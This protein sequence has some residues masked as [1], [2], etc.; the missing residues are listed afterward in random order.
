MSR[1]DFCIM[2]N[3][4]ASSSA[5]DSEVVSVTSLSIGPLI[6]L[7][8]SKPA[9]AAAAVSLGDGN[10]EELSSCNKDSVVVIEGVGFSVVIVIAF[11]AFAIG[12]MLMSSLWFIYVKT[13]K[14]CC[15]HHSIIN[16]L[17][18]EWLHANLSLK[19]LIFVCYC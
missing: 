13:S 11:A 2:S 16:V 4:V 9:A 6:P 17:Y 1:R 10:D 7:P 12:V 3:I 19:L 18:F 14:L 15:I 5:M 8:G